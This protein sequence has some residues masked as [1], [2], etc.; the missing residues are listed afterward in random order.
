[1]TRMRPAAA[2]GWGIVG[3]ICGAAPLGLFAV[4]AVAG[5]GGPATSVAVF[6]LPVLASTVGVVFVIL[7]L[8]RAEQKS[9]AYSVVAVAVFAGMVGY[10]LWLYLGLL[11]LQFG[12]GPL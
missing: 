8:L 10:L 7:R 1:M 12:N 5:L 2:A 6:G 9:W 3:L 11:A 4:A